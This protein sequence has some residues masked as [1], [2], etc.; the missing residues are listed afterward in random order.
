MQAGPHR[1][2]AISDLTCADSACIG[3]GCRLPPEAAATR[4]SFFS[5]GFASL[6]GT[7]DSNG[8]WQSRRCVKGYPAERY[9]AKLN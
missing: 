2:T 4:S 8:E 5:V 9:I 7:D 1:R 3:S 6:M